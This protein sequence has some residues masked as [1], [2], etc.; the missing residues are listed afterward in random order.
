MQASGGM[1]READMGFAP[2]SVQHGIAEAY[3]KFTEY[4]EIIARGGRLA[5]QFGDSLF[6]VVVFGQ[7]RPHLIEG[8]GSAPIEWP[9]VL[10]ASPGP[11]DF[12]VQANGMYRCRIRGSWIEV[13]EANFIKIQTCPTEH[14]LQPL[15]DLSD[16]QKETRVRLQLSTHLH[17]TGFTL[18]LCKFRPLLWVVLSQTN[19]SLTIH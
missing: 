7:P 14:S 9:D 13:S 4:A 17:H 11:E 8:D 6:Y 10:R 18:H 5:P 1:S 19:M 16:E 15:Q 2:Y 12:Q 3:T